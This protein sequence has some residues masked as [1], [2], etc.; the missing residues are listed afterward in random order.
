MRNT[1][2]SD[3]N[4][5]SII[6]VLYISYSSSHWMLMNYIVSTNAGKM[7]LICW[8]YKLFLSASDKGAYLSFKNIALQCC[9]LFTA[10]VTT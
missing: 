10:R 8:I 4:I 9:F 6:E 7:C 5:K 2:S 3:T 1:I